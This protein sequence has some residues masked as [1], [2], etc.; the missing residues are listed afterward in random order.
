MEKVIRGYKYE[1]PINQIL[2]Q[3]NVTLKDFRD[4]TNIIEQLDSIKNLKK[5]NYSEIRPEFGDGKLTLI[6][7]KLDQKTKD[8]LGG[9]LKYFITDFV[10]AEPTDDNKKK[11]VDKS[12]EMLCLREACFDEIKVNHNFRI[13]TNSK[14]K[15]LGIIYDDD[16]IESFKKEV[17]KIRKKFIVYVFSLDESAREEEFEDIEDLVELKPIPAVILNVYRRIFK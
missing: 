11:M 16:G 5:R 2:F 8:G 6:G 1:G 15:L 9:N 10:D 17:K 7:T 12:T 3:K 13:F 14:E 4:C